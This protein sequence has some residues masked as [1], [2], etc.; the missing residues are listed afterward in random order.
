M[1]L[2]VVRAVNDQWLS[3]AT[4]ELNAQF[5]GNRF[6]YF[7][8]N[9]KDVIEL[10]I[11]FLGPRLQPVVHVDQ[12]HVDAHLIAGL[13]QTSFENMCHSECSPDFLQIEI[14]TLELESRPARRHFQ[15]RNLCERVEY[16]LRNA[17]T[18]VSGALIVA[19]VFEREDR[20]AFFGDGGSNS[21]RRLAVESETFCARRRESSALQTGRRGVF[22]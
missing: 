8:L 12:L 3:G 22:V 16:F 21:C 5:G 15:A 1:R 19:K 4:R 2:R 10:A 6:G 20:N 14:A 17:I 7:I 13:L 9:C 11:V 18:E